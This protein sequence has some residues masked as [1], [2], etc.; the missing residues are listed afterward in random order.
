M[1][2]VNAGDPVDASPAQAKR[3]THLIAKKYTPRKHSLHGV[4]F[5]S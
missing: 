2:D 1:R 3:S 4:V 5:Q